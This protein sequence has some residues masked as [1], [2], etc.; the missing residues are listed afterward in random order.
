MCGV[1]LFNISSQPL[2][3]FELRKKKIQ[4]ALYDKFGVKVDLC[5]QGHG[6][7]NT[8]NLARRCFS[9]PKSLADCLELDSTFVK[10][11]A[12]IIICFKSKKQ[13]DLDKLEKFCIDTYWLHY[14]LYPWSRMNPSTHK[15]LVHG[16]QIARKFPLPIA[17]FSEDSSESWHKLNRENMKKRSRQN[18]RQNRILDVFNRAVYLSDPKISLMYI[19]NRLRFHKDKDVPQ[20]ITQYFMR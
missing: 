18:S 16:C 4:A 9:D 2:D 17:F 7:T 3:K 8:G 14:T 20:E 1:L 6:T 11:I 5:L 19:K 13:L 15:L 10:N 12:H